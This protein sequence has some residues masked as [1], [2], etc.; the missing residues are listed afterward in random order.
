MN[1]GTF[2][3]NGTRYKTNK[4]SPMKQF[5]IVRRIGPILSDLMPAMGDIAKSL[6]ATGTQPEK[7]DFD[8]IAKFVSPIMSGLSKLDDADSELVLYGLLSGVERNQ[9]GAWSY[10]S[11]GKT[12]MFQDLDLP[13]MLQLAGRSFMFNLSGF[14]SALPSTSP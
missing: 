13:A 11:D 10:V 7:I 2:E 6:K 5:H 8:Q 1:E 3:L 14:F 4:I 12:L 9:M